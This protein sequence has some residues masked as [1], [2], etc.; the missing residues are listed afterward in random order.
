MACEYVERFEQ[1]TRMWQTD[2]RQTDLATVKCV[3]IGGIAEST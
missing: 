3:G 1:E 2:D